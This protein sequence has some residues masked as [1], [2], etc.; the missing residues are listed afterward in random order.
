MFRY[1]FGKR[2]KGDISLPVKPPRNDGTA[3]GTVEMPVTKTVEVL[4]HVFR[5]AVFTGY[6]Y[7][8]YRVQGFLG[9]FL[10][11]TMLTIHGTLDFLAARQQYTYGWA[12][13]SLS[14]VLLCL[15]CTIF[16]NRQILPWLEKGVSMLEKGQKY[17]KTLKR[18]EKVFK[19]S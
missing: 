3:T 1:L 13:V 8:N 15:V 18:F 14:L 4:R 2:G 12:S 9:G 7:G 10:W 17:P 6:T 16:T 19:V 11:L 5:V